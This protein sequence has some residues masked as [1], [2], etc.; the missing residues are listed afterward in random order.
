MGTYF[1]PTFPLT[2]AHVVL[3]VPRLPY[4][5]LV[6]SVKWVGVSHPSERWG[7]LCASERETKVS[8]HYLS[9]SSCWLTHGHKP[10]AFT[11]VCGGGALIF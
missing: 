10:A 3:F 4:L 8:E 6:K 1:K 2:L 7:S 11:A 9:P 5:P